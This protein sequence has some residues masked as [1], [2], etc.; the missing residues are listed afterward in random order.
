MSGAKFAKYAGRLSTKII[1]RV[2]LD[3]V[4][5]LNEVIEK[6]PTTYDLLGGPNRMMG[7]SKEKRAGF[8]L[9]SIL[10]SE[11]IPE[12]PT[13]DPLMINGVIL[14]LFISK[15]IGLKDRATSYLKS[16]KR[17]DINVILAK[18]FPDD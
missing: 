9:Y 13:E 5:M 11:T 7:N 14:F 1:D 18:Y 4:L 10:I 3:D 12:A 17:P 2:S 15:N 8:N 6:C 16:L